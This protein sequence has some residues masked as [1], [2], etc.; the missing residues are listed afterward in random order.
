M[1]LPLLTQTRSDILN[2][3]CTQIRCYP[4][5]KYTIENWAKRYEQ[6]SPRKQNKT[7]PSLN[8]RNANQNHTDTI[9]H[10][11]GW[12][13]KVSDCTVAIV[14][15]LRY[16]PQQEHLG[17]VWS[18]GHPQAAGRNGMCSVEGNL[19][20]PFKLFNAHQF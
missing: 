5:Y 12:Q 10:F 1:Y 19:A 20:I 11:L 7:K 9:F 14:R 16:K 6:G 8:K 18:H 4:K 17:K 3:E 15:V 13:R 2:K